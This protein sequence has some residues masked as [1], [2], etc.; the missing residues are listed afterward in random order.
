MNDL[1]YL[2]RSDKNGKE[3]RNLGSISG[4]MKPR[5]GWFTNPGSDDDQCPIH[6]DGG[7]FVL[8]FEQM[9]VVMELF[10]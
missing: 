7:E 5:H 6:Q 4:Y 10:P 9:L 3:L 2:H 8:C 1:A